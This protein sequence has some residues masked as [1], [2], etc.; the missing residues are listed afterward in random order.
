MTDGDGQDACTYFRQWMRGHFTWHGRAGQD[1]LG[2]SYCLHWAE[3]QGR[4]T[5]WGRWF[6]ISLTA[7]LV[8]ERDSGGEKKKAI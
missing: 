5:G 8:V 2:L 6:G 3:G 1:G 4:W 7:W